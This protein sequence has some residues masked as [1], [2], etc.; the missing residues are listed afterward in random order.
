[1]RGGENILHLV[2]AASDIFFF[3]SQWV[4]EKRGSAG[5]DRGGEL[6]SNAHGDD[7]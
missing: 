7:D 2:A 6:Q 4:K 1:M 3:S 5:E